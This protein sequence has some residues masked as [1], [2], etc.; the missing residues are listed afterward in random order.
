MHRL[1]RH[2]RSQAVAYAALFVA[3]GGTGYAA[4]TL[5]RGSV[6][7]RQL[8]NHSITPIKFDSSTIAGYVRDW[9]QISLQGQLTASR[10][11][12]TLIG[13]GARGGQIQW[14]KPIPVNCFAVATTSTNGGQV[15]YASAQAGGTGGHADAQ[16]AVLLSAPAQVNV[17]IICPQP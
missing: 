6:G 4:V 15:T 5:P 17:A 10:P 12:A 11:H 9:A 7:N 14:S 2:L 1:L 3:L 13:W 16:T 8:R